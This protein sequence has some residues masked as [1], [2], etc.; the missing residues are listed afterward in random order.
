[1]QC[2]NY[3]KMRKTL[4][5]SS[6]PTNLFPFLTK[7]SQNKIQTFLS[8]NALNKGFTEESLDF[9]KVGILRR[10]NNIRNRAEEIILHELIYEESVG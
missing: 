4:L 9:S 5:F 2:S 8:E 7:E 10:M 1:M 3:D 6:V